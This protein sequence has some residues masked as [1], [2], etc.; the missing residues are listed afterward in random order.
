MFSMWGVWRV[1]QHCKPRSSPPLSELWRSV[2]ANFCGANGEFK[3]GKFGSFDGGFWTSI[4]EAGTGSQN[5]SLSTVSLRSP[6]DVRSRQ[7]LISG[8]N[9]LGVNDFSCD[10]LHRR[11]Q[12]FTGVDSKFNS[13]A[14]SNRGRSSY[15]ERGKSAIMRMLAYGRTL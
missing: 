4:G 9:G 2:T 12:L 10:R 6:L 8:L 15:C 3:Y 13:D 11:S 5:P 14:G 1:A 7:I